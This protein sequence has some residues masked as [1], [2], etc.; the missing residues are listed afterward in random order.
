MWDVTSSTLPFGSSPYSVSNIHPSQMTPD[1]PVEPTM[2]GTIESSPALTRSN[3]LESDATLPSPPLLISPVEVVVKLAFPYFE[4]EHAESGAYETPAE[5][6]GA[7]RHEMWMYQHALKE[8][9]GRTVPKCF[10]MMRAKVQPV[11]DEYHVMHLKPC[12][13]ESNDEHGF[14]VYAM[15]LQRLFPAFPA[16]PSDQWSMDMR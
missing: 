3:S 16:V 1:I 12:D 15:I 14:F 6:E 4:N 7:V 5:K 13:P 8:L 10:A 11:Y 9:Q 2:E